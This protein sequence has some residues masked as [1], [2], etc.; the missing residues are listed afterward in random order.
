MTTAKRKPIK[1]F[2]IDRKIWLRGVGSEKSMLMD[3]DG[4]KCCLG[5][6]GTACGISDVNLLGKR[7]PA[8]EGGRIKGFGSWLF[9]KA[10]NSDY[11]VSEACR[12]LM[13]D[14][15]NVSLIQSRRE[16]LIKAGFAKAGI[17]VR[18]KN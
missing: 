10:S 1:S 12:Q 7:D 16:A 15:D 18:F 4:K 17:K 9:K 3:E 11:W 5:I 2:T 13:C 8:H 6:Y 14:N